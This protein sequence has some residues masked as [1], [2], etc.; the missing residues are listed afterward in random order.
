MPITKTFLEWCS[1]NGANELL[2]C[3]QN[4]Q[5]STPADKIGFSSSSKVSFLCPS[6]NYQWSRSLN[7]ATRNGSFLKCPACNGRMPWGDNIWTKKYPLL[8]AQWDYDKNQG[9][10]EDYRITNKPIYWHCKKCRNRWTATLKDRIRSAKLVMTKGGEL[11]PFC[12]G[13][14]ISPQYNLSVCYPDI[15]RQWDYIKN[16]NL[17]PDNCF[18]SG[19]KTVW[20]RCDFNPAHSW[21]DR[22]SNR[23]L[24]RRGCP[25]C[26]KTFKMTYTSRVL[27]YCLR[28]IFPDC[29]CEYPEGPY[30][31][32]IC[33]P[34]YKIAIEHHG[35]T[36]NQSSSRERDL[37]RKNK[38][39]D[40]GYRHVLWIVE[41]QTP[42][43][44]DLI[45]KDCIDKDVL[46]YY[47]P[48]PYAKMN[49]LICTVIEWLIPLVGENVSFDKPDFVRDHWKIERAYYH[50][51]KKRTLAVQRPDL[52]LEWSEKNKI[53]PNTVTTGLS[54]NFLWNC[55]DCHREYYATIHNRVKNNSACPYCSGHLPTEQNNAA[56]HYPHLVSEWDEEKNDKSLS[57][58]LPSTKYMAHWICRVCGHHWQTMLYNR[59]KPSGSGCPACK[60]KKQQ[61]KGQNK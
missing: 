15:A 56:I 36:H 34:S 7:K 57:D 42:T 10:P 32:D 13:Q 29:A 25:Y 50:E 60:E 19:S 35:Y 8:L 41:N 24:L 45:D 20:W 23:T 16:G 14:R 39:L 44:N 2:E 11:C 26:T 55:P 37:L 5:N 22:I 21:R 61:L 52:A 27:F 33:I 46:Q 40:K 53:R 49:E 48:A 9:K 30:H 18:P 58:L 43:N 51:C 54:K 1:E 47:D 6:C 17:L 38:L 4:G 59:A 31:I 28:Q 12:S 3:Y